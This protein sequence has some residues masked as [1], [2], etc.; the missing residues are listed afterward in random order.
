MSFEMPAP[1]SESGPDHS[2]FAASLAR[3]LPPARETEFAHSILQA[4][5]EAARPQQHRQA[6]TQRLFGLVLS[7]VKGCYLL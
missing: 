7:G 4:S 6:M 2:L 5:E 1:L 3:Q